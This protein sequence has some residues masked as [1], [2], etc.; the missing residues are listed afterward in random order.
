MS[1]GPELHL[2]LPGPL[3]QRTGGYLY[4]SRMVDGLR[5]QGW[6]VT[7]HG[8]EGSFPDADEEAGESVV[9]AL[10]TLPDGVRVLVD[11]LALPAASPSLSAHSNRL[12]PLGLIHHLTSEET[13]INKILIRSL[14]LRE[15]EALASCLGVIVTSG[16][17]ASRVERLG[18]PS[19]L[20][21]AVEPGI[22][23]AP[24]ARGP[25]SGEPA[26]LLCVGSIIPRK[27]QDT[28]VQALALLREHSWDLRPGR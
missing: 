6:T 21:R 3:D 15:V 1:S 11:S 20:I 17:T 7:V 10:A 14:R 2:L 8:L 4:N 16:F 5:R 18:V 12:R 19:A 28:L 9:G 13:R 25:D 26:R 27:G 22:E 23:P 24:P